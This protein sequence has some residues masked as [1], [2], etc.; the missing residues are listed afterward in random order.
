MSDSYKNFHW[1]KPSRSSSTTVNLPLSS[2]P[3][4]H[5]PKNLICTNAAPLA[6]AA[7]FATTDGSERPVQ[8]K[9]KASDTQ[10]EASPSKNTSEPALSQQILSLCC[11]HTHGHH[12]ASHADTCSCMNALS[13]YTSGHIPKLEA[14]T[15]LLP[16]LMLPLLFLR[17]S[18]SLGFFSFSAFRGHS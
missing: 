17:K 11:R 15:P 9:K 14:F 8:G 7:S 10:G 4:D 12:C 2:S 18:V 6:I 1:R 3:L 5:A 16:L 13:L